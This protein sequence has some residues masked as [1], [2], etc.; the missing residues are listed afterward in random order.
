LLL[1][2]TLHPTP[3]RAGSPVQATAA[4][5]KTAQAA[6]VAHGDAAQDARQRARA[7]SA[8][9]ALLAEQQVAAAARL[10]VLENQT[11]QAAGSLARLQAES[12]AQVTALQASEVALTALLPIMQRLSAAPAAT[13][14]ATPESSVDSVRGILVLQALAGEIAT[15]SASVRAQA[16]SVASLLAQISAQQHVL[17]AAVAAEK[18]AEDRL[19]AQI[20]AARTAEMAD[21][22]T[23]VAQAAA[24]LR[25]DQSV[26]DLRDAIGNLQA[27][28]PSVAT[29]VVARAPAP[30]AQALGGTPAPLTQAFGSAP[31]SG[32]VVE[33]FGDPT[34]AGPAQGITYKAAPGA[35]V[36]APCA[37]P[38]LFADH[39]KSYGLL[40][41]LGCNAGTDFVLSGMNR[42]DV[43]AGQKI[44]R[45]QPIGEMTGFDAKNP[46]S[47]PHLYV[48]LLLNGAPVSPVLLLAA[49]G[50]G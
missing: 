26:R 33:N 36:V 20:N 50:A 42:L 35:R 8:R 44:A 38:V 3:G 34:I 15:R 39:F 11:G 27:A 4:Q 7:D 23:A 48:E 49:G 22:D 32:M 19:T 30:P 14:L 28:A 5:V 29:P 43:A 31:V 10:R 24:A 9:A 17:L 12:A 46:A 2:M 37:G 40:V 21:L 18:A 25:A 6:A 13:I 16:A 1:L 47:E 45:G 41:I